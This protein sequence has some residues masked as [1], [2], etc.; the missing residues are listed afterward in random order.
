[1]NPVALIAWQVRYE[2]K[3]FWR[4][5]TAAVFVVFF[6]VLFL[7]LFGGNNQRVAQLGGIPYR[8]FFVPSML[9]Y[10]LMNATYASL[11]LAL[12]NRRENGLLRRLRITPLPAWASF[13]GLVGNALVVA[14][15][16]GTVVLTLG[17]GAYG[18]SWP[19]HYLALVLALV[20]GVIAFA[21]LG[22]AVSTLVPNEDAAGPMVNVIYFVLIFTSGTFFPVSPHSLLGRIA[23]VFPV[24]HLNRAIL[25]A[26]LPF[27][28][29]GITHGFAWSDIGVVALWG[30][31]GSY[32]AVRRWRWE[33]RRKR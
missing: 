30:V 26:F 1:M 17:F 31:A 14:G 5:P 4:N 10:G 7:V 25:T 32:L 20:V 19:G 18:L 27:G 22:A 13:A 33:P 3:A 28:P 6:P 29:H 11:A 15:L 2:Q 12:V 23:S 24:A 8:Q 21:A 9:A 16:I